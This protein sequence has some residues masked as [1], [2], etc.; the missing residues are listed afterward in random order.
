MK[1]ILL[2]IGSV[3]VAT[4]PV[5][6]A[7]SCSMGEETIHQDGIKIVVDSDNN[8]KS[9]EIDGN[10]YKDFN[11]AIDAIVRICNQN[12]V[13]SPYNPRYDATLLSKIN[14]TGD[15]T[16]QQSI[17][18]RIEEVS[19]PILPLGGS[20]TGTNPRPV[21]G[22]TTSGT[23]PRPVSG[24]TTSGTTSGTTLGTNPGPVSGATSGGST[25]QVVA[26]T[27]SSA[28]IGGRDFVG[29]T[30]NVGFGTYTNVDGFNLFNAPTR[31]QPAYGGD[32]IPQRPTSGA[33]TFV[34]PTVVDASASSRLESIMHTFADNEMNVKN[35]DGTIVRVP[36]TKI[37][38]PGDTAAERMEV[39][40]F[41][42]FTL[43]A[44]GQTS[45]KT[46]GFYDSLG[47]VSGLLVHMMGPID[48]LPKKLMLTYPDGRIALMHT[49]SPK[50]ATH[51]VTGQQVWYIDE[52]IKT[53]DIL[54][55]VQEASDAN[56]ATPFYYWN[57]A[58]NQNEN[59]DI[60]GANGQ[61]VRTGLP[62]IAA[63]FGINLIGQDNKVMQDTYQIIQ[64]SPYIVP[65]SSLDMETFG[66]NS[67][68]LTNL[69]TEPATGDRDNSL[70]WTYYVDSR[71]SWQLGY[72]T[73]D[74]I[75][76]TNPANR[77]PL[78]NQDGTR[79]STNTA[80]W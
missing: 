46:S 41:G 63:T 44:T 22:G 73:Q 72:D 53:I 30:P 74:G 31:P 34:K 38:F 40:H 43:V 76:E 28:Q 3:A 57:M 23:N 70:R 2:G 60:R 36:S 4:T 18:S 56:G 25:N 65:A 1:K 78:F 67:S 54:N 9:V 26:P 24:G 62:D 58:M 49:F 61:L 47:S 7:V 13:A 37:A 27:G 6:L 77:H 71:N 16:L 51:P 15:Q 11:S 17:D 29:L 66:S 75:G 59:N 64:P 50:L 21:S 52:F 55:P 35:P 69:Y 80:R 39:D 45:G 33:S 8:I 5:V 20:T 32:R 14:V 79:I 68:D 42:K 48:S 10:K 12:R 19:G